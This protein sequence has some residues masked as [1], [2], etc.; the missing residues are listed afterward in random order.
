[1]P[2]AVL[3][4]TI[5]VSAFLTPKGPAAELL[6][7]ARKGAFHVCLSEE[8]L[9]ET[10]EVLLGR[11]HIRKRHPYSDE[12]AVEFCQTLRAAVFLAS[13]LPK[14]KGLTR[15]PADDMIL[16]CAEKAQAHYLVTR[17][18]DLLALSKHQE[19]RILSPEDFLALLRKQGSE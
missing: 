4:S 19:I 11:E 13:D 18:K 15:D 6:S 7:Y 16:A 3:D 17:D 9:Q 14:L 8:I 1:M 10:Q 5:L 2:R 12:E